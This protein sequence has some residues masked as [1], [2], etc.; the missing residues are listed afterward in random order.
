MD[1]ERLSYLRDREAR[2]A[3]SAIAELKQ[4]YSGN[5]LDDRYVLTCLAE[6]ERNVRMALSNQAK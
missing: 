6:A 3:L 5:S 1:N 4:L 2:R